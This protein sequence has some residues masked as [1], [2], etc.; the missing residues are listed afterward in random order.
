MQRWGVEPFEEL[1]RDIHN[2]EKRRGDLPVQK[3]GRAARAVSAHLAEAD[4]AC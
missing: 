2:F 4:V 1:T 3:V